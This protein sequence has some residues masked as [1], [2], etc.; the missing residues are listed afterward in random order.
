LGKAVFQAE[1]GDT[2]QAEV[3]T[4]QSA[5]Y[6]AKALEMSKGGAK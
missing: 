1:I 2:K 4:K 6:S 5:S 3:F